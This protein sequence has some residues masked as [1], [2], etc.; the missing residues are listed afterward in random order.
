MID[1]ISLSNLHK[2]G[3]E[4][5]HFDMLAMRVPA[6]A[7]ELFRQLGQKQLYKWNSHNFEVMDIFS[8]VSFER[9]SEDGYLLNTLFSA[10]LA[11]L[12]YVEDPQF[13]A[14]FVQI[15]SEELEGDRKE[16]VEF[17]QKFSCISKTG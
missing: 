15:D 6:Q 5:S 12:Y 3:Q 17:I 11:W 7:R 10:P 4:Q 2:M 16:I 1:C 13:Q 8:Q 9:I 14:H